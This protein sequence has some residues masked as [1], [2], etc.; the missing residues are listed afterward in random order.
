MNPSA[1]PAAA[2]SEDTQHLSTSHSSTVTTAK[3]S[4]KQPKR[5]F[6]NVSQIIRLL[7]SKPS[8][9]SPHLLGVEAKILAMFW[10]AFWQYISPAFKKVLHLDLV[11]SLLELCAKER[12]RDLGNGALLINK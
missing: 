4:A 12:I 1:K 2:P 10:R 8:N 7:H 3:A 11:I 5:S 9:I 6:Q